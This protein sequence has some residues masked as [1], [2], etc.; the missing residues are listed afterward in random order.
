MPKPIV[1]GNWKM[2]TTVSEALKLAS[3][4]R[5]AVGSLSGVDVVVCPPFISLAAV[6]EALRGS[7]IMLGAQNMYPEA[8]GAVT[9]EIS[10]AMLAGLCDFVILGHSERRRLLVES[11]QFI[12]R[13]V[14]AALGAGLRPILCVGET[15]E[16][17]K[18]GR[19]P[20]MVRSQLETC[21]EGVEQCQGLLVAYEPVWAIGSG[22]SASSEA[23][24]EMMGE[25]VFRTLAALYGE[26]EALEV[27]LLYGGSVTPDNWAGFAAQPWVHGAL[28]GGTSLRTSQFAEII[29]IAALAKGGRA[30]SAP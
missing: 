20:D 1:V 3:E 5:E 12:S 13:K 24:Q 6:K 2:H 23:V 18:W 10:Y 22:V 9:G 16:Q 15:L 27:P 19:A 11:D 21:L 30:G 28:V 4:V 25:V 14:K 17:R 8:S 29:R 7:A 26:H